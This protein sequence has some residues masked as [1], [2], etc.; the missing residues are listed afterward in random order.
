METTLKRS[1][2]HRLALLL[3]VVSLL[4]VGCSD[5]GGGD[6]TASGSSSP[7]SGAT[8]F[9]SG[10]GG[11]VPSPFASTSYSPYGFEVCEPKQIPTPDWIPDDLPL[12][13]GIYATEAED[14]LSGYNRVFMVI[15]GTTTI[16]EFTRMVVKEWKRAGYQL[17]RGDSEQ[18]EV[19]AEFSKPPATGAFKVQATACHDPSYSVM[20]LIYA[21]N[22][23]ILATPSPTPSK[24]K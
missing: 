18:G 23:P 10:T 22:G 9:P 17:G 8:P 3:L 6:P 2:R 20:Y 4:A 13:E 5:K 19:E 24:K 14:P 21:P 7:S 15:P 11:I 1:G 12:P 16:P